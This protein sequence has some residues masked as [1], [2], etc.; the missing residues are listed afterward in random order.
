MAIVGLPYVCLLVTSVIHVTLS[1]VLADIWTDTALW[2]NAV[3]LVL[4]DRWWNNRL[5]DHVLQ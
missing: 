3:H 5:S 2:Q 1:R 4:I